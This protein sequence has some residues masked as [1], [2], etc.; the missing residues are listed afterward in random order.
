M[1][2]PCRWMIFVDGEN[3]TL[4]AQRIA[5]ANGVE[6][7]E[8][9]YLQRDTLFW[10]PPMTAENPFT[11]AFHPCLRIPYPTENRCIR[12]H[13][14]TA[15][16]G[17]EEKAHKTR[18]ALRNLHFEPEVFT[19]IHGKSK[20]VD[21]K[22]ARDVLCH[23]FRDNYDL[24][25]LV[26]GDG[27]YVPLVDEM[28]R[29]GRIVCVY[30]FDGPGSGLSEAL[31]LSADFFQGLDKV[32]FTHWEEYLAKQKD[33]PAIWRRSQGELQRYCKDPPGEDLEVRTVHGREWTP[34]CSPTARS[35]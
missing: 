1:A 32:V 15:V 29:L 4:Q 23:A 3:L 17:N 26:A 16:K 8:G 2:T 10:I 24:A 27:D 14:Y 35:R 6:L 30:F 13:Y 18:L 25:V 20:G 19:K 11:T 21:I 9:K 28:K 22:L 34:E 12:A 33:S 7:L 5:K 31:R